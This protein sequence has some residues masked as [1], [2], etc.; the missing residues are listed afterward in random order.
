MAELYTISDEFNQPEGL[1]QKNAGGVDNPWTSTVF[2][3]A[4]HPDTDDNF[5]TN[6][7]HVDLRSFRTVSNLIPVPQFPDLDTV[8][9]NPNLDTVFQTDLEVKPGD[10][11]SENWRTIAGATGLQSTFTE[12]WELTT[13]YNSGDGVEYKGKYYKANATTQGEFPDVAA[14]WDETFFVGKLDD[15]GGW[16]GLRALSNGAALSAVLRSVIRE[17]DVDISNMDALSMVFPDY[18]N[19][20]T[21][22]SYVWLTSHPE[23]DFN[24][25][26]WRSPQVLFSSNTS[27][28]P[29][30]RF[31]LSVFTAGAGVN[32][33]LES[34]TGIQIGLVGNSTPSNG[35][36]ITL[37]A[38]RAATDEW[39]ESSLD[40]ETRWGT[41]QPPVTLDGDPYVGTVASDFEFVRGDNSH[42]DPYPADGAYTVFFYGGGEV[43]P[44]ALNPLKNSIGIIL[45]ESSIYGNP[46]TQVGKTATG[47]ST[48]N[49]LANQIY[50]VKATTPAQAGATNKVTW[51][52]DGGGPGSG[53]ATFR[54]AIYS[55]NAGEPDDLLAVSNEIQVT[56]AATAANIEFTLTSPVALAASTDYWIAIHG[57]AEADSCRLYYDTVSAAARTDAD[58]YAGGSPD[59][60]DTAG[61]VSEDNQ[62]TAFFEYSTDSGSAI[63]T[64]LKWNEAGLWFEAQRKDMV[65]GTITST[66]LYTEQI[67]SSGLDV[68]L[69]HAW[70]VKL[71]GKTLNSEVFVVDQNRDVQSNIWVLTSIDSDDWS[72]RNGRVGFTADLIDQDAYIDALVTAPVGYALLRTRIYESRDPVDGVRL[73]ATFSPDANLFTEL[74]GADAF[75]DQT[76]TISGQGSIRTLNGL[77]TNNFI[78]EDWHETYLKLAIWTPASV[79]TLNQPRIELNYA[80]V[81]Y[82]LRVPPLKGAQWN[83]LYFELSN[84]K[85]FITGLGYSF[86]ILPGASP[87]I[88]LG[89]YWVD[90]VVIGRRKVAWAARANPTAPFRRFRSMVNRA[91]GAVHFIPIERGRQLQLEAQA[92][93]SDAWISEFTLFPHYAELGLPVYDQG[94]ET[95]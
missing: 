51:R 53:T 5:L 58:T 82:P 10:T 6:Q 84:F 93:T 74:T 67:N 57:D 13:T 29:E 61:D 36:K 95:R 65:N 34:I 83:H 18:N 64:W 1:W 72:F 90:S 89:F 71:V 14:A 69:L 80:S 54:A 28:L 75:R 46:G 20:N 87:D 42:F 55:N 2:W 23:G 30:L 77:T 25:A 59:P 88:P 35:T 63:Y 73:Q 52:I 70:T 37:M 47:G 76:K 33:A 22:S 92:L 26:A 21:A 15:R 16:Y 50:A 40:F 81:G 24:E 31:D 94:F 62:Y 41:L 3:N 60:W 11:F 27:T 4:V 85:D 49:M 66:T 19:F 45:R 12:Y 32:F 43:D 7:S 39:V 38:I 56:D 79:T 86:S 78:A 91:D 9:Q 68:S 48:A 44:T 8:P 17:D